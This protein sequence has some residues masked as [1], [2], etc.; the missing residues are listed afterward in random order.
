MDVRGDGVRT[1]SGSHC[2]LGYGVV[3]AAA[4]VADVEHD[5]T[6]LGGKGRRQ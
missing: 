4:A 6:L 3:E 2:S 5:A 1:G